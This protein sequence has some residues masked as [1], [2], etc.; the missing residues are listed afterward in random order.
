[1]KR[2]T[3][4]SSVDE[5]VIK[6]FKLRNETFINYWKN[7][8]KVMRRLNLSGDHITLEVAQ[9]VLDELMEI[10]NDVKGFNERNNTKFTKSTFDYELKIM[11]YAV[12]YH[13][14][15]FPKHL[16]KIVQD[17]YKTCSI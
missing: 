9:R 7:R 15:K 3:F 13:K 2:I 12:K 11:R 4:S 1:M 10:K 14:Y 5:D 17:K 8:C 6:Q 16:E